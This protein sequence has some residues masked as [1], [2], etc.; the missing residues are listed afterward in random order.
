MAEERDINVG[1]NLTRYRGSHSQ[2]AIADA[3]RERGWKWSQATMWSIEKGDRPVRLVEAADLA[4]VLQ[5][6]IEDLLA[7]PSVAQAAR[8][9]IDAAEEVLAAYTKAVRAIDTLDVVRDDLTIALDRACVFP[10]WQPDASQTELIEK[11]LG[12]VAETV[13]EV[14]RIRKARPVTAG[15]KTEAIDNLAKAHG[16]EFTPDTWRSERG[17]EPLDTEPPAPEEG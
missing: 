3:M 15:A 9:A 10:D 11:A 14:A 7:R 6:S 8:D 5:I 12:S 16:T 4:V 1:K 17:V 13:A 2:Q